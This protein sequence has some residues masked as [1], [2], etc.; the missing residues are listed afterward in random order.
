MKENFKIINLTKD[1]IDKFDNY[2]TNFPNRDIELKK[3]LYNSAYEMLKLLFECNSTNDMK[4][5]VNLQDRIVSNVKFLDFLICRCYKRQIINHK[6]Y[7]KFGEDLE[8]IYASLIKWKAIT[9][10]AISN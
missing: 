5:R 3:N 9:I 10:K 7:L 8:Y 2:L 1:L 6:R 4:L